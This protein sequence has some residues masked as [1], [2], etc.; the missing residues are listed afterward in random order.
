MLTTLTIVS[1][2]QGNLNTASRAIG[3]YDARLL[4]DIG[5]GSARPQSQMR[6]RART[7][8]R[9]LRPSSTGRSI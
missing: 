7:F 6:R 5:W 1:L 9:W 2:N 4:E 8:F 3:Q